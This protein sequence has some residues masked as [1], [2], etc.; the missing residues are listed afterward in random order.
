MDRIKTIT[1]IVAIIG[2]SIFCGIGILFRKIDLFSK[3]NHPVIKRNPN[4]SKDFGMI[5]ILIAL[6]CLLVTV[7]GTCFQ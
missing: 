3:L 4:A 7:V 2:A 1:I 6:I 5:M